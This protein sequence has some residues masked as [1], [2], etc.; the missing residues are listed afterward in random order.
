[1][2]PTQQLTERKS[3]DDLTFDELMAW[4]NGEDVPGLTHPE[5]EGHS[6]SS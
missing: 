5:D 6:Q 1:V 4:A 3:V 2:Q